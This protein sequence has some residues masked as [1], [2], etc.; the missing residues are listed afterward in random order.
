MTDPKP[1]TKPGPKPLPAEQQ[2][3]LVSVRLTADE[4]QA[5]QKLGVVEWLRPLLRRERKRLEREGRL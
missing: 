5:L 4:R 1:R 3:G 2:T